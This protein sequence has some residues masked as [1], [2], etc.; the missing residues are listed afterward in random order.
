M[1]ISLFFNYFNLKDDFF[2]HF[3]FELEKPFLV[4]SYREKEKIYSSFAF[5]ESKKGEKI[6]DFDGKG[7]GI[8]YF[9]KPQVSKFINNLKH[10][11]SEFLIIKN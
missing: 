8:S 10:D 9:L 11:E 1:E 5:E 4:V 6:V 3:N 7:H 2:S